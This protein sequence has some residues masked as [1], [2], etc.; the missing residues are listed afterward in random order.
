MGPVSSNSL[1]GAGIE[2]RPEVVAPVL[3]RLLHLSGSQS[4]W[5][6][7][8]LQ[9]AQAGLISSEMPSRY[10]P[11]GHL[12]YYASGGQAPGGQRGRAQAGASSCFLRPHLLPVLARDL[13]GPTPRL[14]WPRQCHLLQLS[15]SEESHWAWGQEHIPA[16]TSERVL[17]S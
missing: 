11:L 10:S 6:L 15:W 16:A 8:L 2:R 7:V 13:L 17:S 9:E 3:R 4:S 1:P 5:G 14:G 12:I